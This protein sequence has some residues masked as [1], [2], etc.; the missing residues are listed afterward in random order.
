MAALARVGAR[1]LRPL[2]EP[3]PLLSGPAPLRLSP[4]REGE[5][6]AAEEHPR[7]CARDAAVHTLPEKPLLHWRGSTRPDVQQVVIRCLVTPLHRQ[8]VDE[9][10][11]AA[12]ELT[13]LTEDQR[14][15]ATDLLEPSLERPY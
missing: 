2:R 9:A 13:V 10:L 1:L 11:E 12:R 5:L 14:R 15:D 3:S 8:G 4:P 6:E 7:L